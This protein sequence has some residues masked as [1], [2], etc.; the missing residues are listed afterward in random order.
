VGAQTS[1]MAPVDRSDGSKDVSRE[2]VI[3][4]RDLEIGFGEKTILDHFELDVYRGE[5][6]GLIGA[7]GSGKSVLLRALVGLIPL[8]HGTIEILGQNIANLTADAQ[9]DLGVR[10]GIMFQYG[11]LFS[12]L[13]VKENVQLPMREFLDLSDRLLDELAM[14][15][16]ESVGLGVDAAGKYPAQLSGGMAKRVALARALALD[17]E[18]VFLD[19]PTSGLDPIGAGDFDALVA[20]L[21]KSLKLTVFMVTHDLDSMRTVCTRII[22][23]AKGRVVAD[24]T[25]EAMLASPHPWM[26]AYFRGTRGQFVFRA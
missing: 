13:T 10:C 22:A 21:Q 24:G 16:L 3:K 4:V 26:N 18:I 19:E 23:V 1:E 11:A 6:L 15:K 7:S 25:L 5:I 20:K 8:Y 9:K 12:S 17:P 2:A 14:F